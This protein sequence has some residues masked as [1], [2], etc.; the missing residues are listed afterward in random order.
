MP[1]SLTKRGVLGSSWEPRPFLIPRDGAARGATPSEPQGQ[2]CSSRHRRAAGDN[3]ERGFSR[4][5]SAAS[6]VIRPIIGDA[7]I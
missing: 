1:K 3:P 2:R 4:N 5:R 6:P 7:L